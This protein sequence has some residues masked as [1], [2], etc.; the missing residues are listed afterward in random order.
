[1]NNKL[2]DNINIILKHANKICPQKYNS[3]YNNEYYL[4]HIIHV[5][6]DVSSWKSLQNLIFNDKKMSPYHYKTINK[7]HIKWSKNNVYTDAFEEIKNNN[8]ECD[9]TENLYIDGTLIINKHGI[10]DV[11]YGCGE[12]KKKKFSSITVVC[13]ENIKPICF[14]SNDVNTKTICTQ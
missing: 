3:K 13:N 2:I 1:M 14:F 5:L 9:V 12:S 8:N 4:K 10:N 6:K 11:G 7:I